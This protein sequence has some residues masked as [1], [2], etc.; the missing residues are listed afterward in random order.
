MELYVKIIKIHV[1]TKKK[2]FIST[3][4]TARDL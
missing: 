1:P 2:E 3:D 4:Y